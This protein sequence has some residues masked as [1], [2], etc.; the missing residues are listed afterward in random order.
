MK[1]FWQNLSYLNKGSKRQQDAYRA[2]KSSGVMEVLASFDPVLVGTIPIGIDLPESDLDII[3]EVKDMEYF[4]QTMELHFS[5]Q[6]NFTIRKKEIGDTEVCL[7]QF[8]HKGFEFELF[9]QAVPVIHQNAFRHMMV[10]HYL[11]N[12]RKPSFRQKIINLKRSGYKTEMAFAM[13]LDLKGNP[14]QALLELEDSI[15]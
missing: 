14:Y 5:N 10:E 13:V 1:S 3:C 12:T 8:Y 11:L 9:G 6:K 7:A 4:F 15:E 2:I